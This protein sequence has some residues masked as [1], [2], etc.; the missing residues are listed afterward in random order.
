SNLLRAGVTGDGIVA[1]GHTI[2]PADHVPDAVTRGMSIVASIRPEKV[3]LGEDVD[4]RCVRLA[5]QVVSVVYL[6]AITHVHLDIG[7]GTE[8]QAVL[9]NPRSSVPAAGARVSIG[10]HP[11]DVQV[12]SPGLE[13]DRG[14][15][16]IEDLDEANSTTRHGASG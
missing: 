1:A 16:D 5:G 9:F 2:L 7:E 15:E 3:L 6:G 10:W 4:D 8:I 11:E 12:M 14:L 13:P